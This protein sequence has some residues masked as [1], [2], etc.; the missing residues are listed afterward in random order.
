MNIV[1]NRPSKNAAEFRNLN[2]GDVFEHGSVIYMKVDPIATALGAIVANAVNLS[3]GEGV[4]FIGERLVTPLS[5]TLVL[6]EVQHEEC[7]EN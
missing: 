1:D 6:N 4:R 5:C 3:N 2:Y 7:N